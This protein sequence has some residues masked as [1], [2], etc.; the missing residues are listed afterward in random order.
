[1]ALLAFSGLPPEPKTYNQAKN[2]PNWQLAMQQEFD[3]LLQNRTWQ[4]V[5]PPNDQHIIDCK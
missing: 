1:V 4:L 3:A 5:P 2:N